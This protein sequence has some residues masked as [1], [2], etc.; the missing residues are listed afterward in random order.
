M[1]PAARE[2]LRWHLDQGHEV[3]VVS[4]SLDLWLAPWMHREGLRLVS[5]RGRF[6]G[7]R[8][9][10]ELD[11]ANVHGPEKVRA[12]GEHV[13]LQGYGVV[14]AYGDSSGDLEMLGLAHEASYRPF[15]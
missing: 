14:Y 1:R 11:G 3:V 10:G 13:D 4:A 15:R 8:F 2:R 6:E 7:E 9:T 12:L 5:T